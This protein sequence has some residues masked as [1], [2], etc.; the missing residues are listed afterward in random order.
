MTAKAHRRHRLKQLLAQVTHAAK[1]LLLIAT[2]LALC[3][4]VTLVWKACWTVI[5]TPP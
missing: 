4:V 3:L 2:S 5:L 1:T